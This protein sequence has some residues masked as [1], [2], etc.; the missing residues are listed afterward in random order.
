MS[1]HTIK[2]SHVL[3]FAFVAIVV[4]RLLFIF[5]EIAATGLLINW[6]PSSSSISAD[7]ETLAFASDSAPTLYVGTWGNGIYRSADNGITWI[8]TTNG[9][10]LPMY[11]RSGLAVNPVTPTILFAGDY[12]GNLSGGG[13]YRSTNGG[14]SW[15]VSLPDANIE[16][17]LIHPLTPT[18]VFAGD[19]ENGLY[20]SVNNGDTWQATSLPAARV[21]ALAASKKGSIFAGADQVLYVSSNSGVSW[22]PTS[23]LS[24]TVESLAV[25]PLTPT[26]V[27]A[28]TH[29]HGLWR[30]INGGTSWI[31][32]TSGLPA[33]AWITSIAIHPIT[34]TILYAAV[35]SGQV[36]RSDDGGATWTGLGYLG[37]VKSVIIHPQAL[38]VIYAATSNNGIFRG[39]TLDHITIDPIST[40]QYVYR[41]FTVTITA[42]DELG[43]PLSAASLL[44]T[45][46]LV[47][48]DA[49]LANTLASGYNSSAILTDTVGLVTPTTVSLINGV[50]S[51]SIMFKQS[52]IT[53]TITATLQNEGL[54][55]VSDAFEVRW[56]AQTYLPLIYRP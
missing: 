30:S 49:R 40:T 2:K 13:V 21:Q 18:L 1:I 8:T 50:G 37:T 19:R 7:I 55:T 6:H 9:I 48:R 54:Q 24:S 44:Q 53:N 3:H 10:T 33:N 56:F 34:P 15:S 16:T 23:T 5:R 32:A 17:L 4:L 25:Q 28:G 47:R 35:C 27:Y 46:S 43:F 12:Y 29:S 11:V 42:H 14:S 22:T 51:Q 39:S 36:Y 31:T 45:Q 26:M 38:S 52:I 20:R 41:P